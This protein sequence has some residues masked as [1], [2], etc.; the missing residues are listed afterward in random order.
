[1]RLELD[2]NGQDRGRVDTMTLRLLRV[3]GNDCISPA[4]HLLAALVKV[5]PERES[6]CSKNALAMAAALY[7]GESSAAASRTCFATFA[8][9]SYLPVPYWPFSRAASRTL[10][11][12][13]TMRIAALLPTV[14]LLCFQL[15][16]MG[17]GRATATGPPDPA[18]LERCPI[19]PHYEHIGTSNVLDMLEASPDHHVLV[20]LVQRAG[21][22]PVL[23]KLQHRGVDLT[24][25]APIDSAWPSSVQAAFSNDSIAE[26]AQIAAL[27]SLLRMPNAS[28]AQLNRELSDLLHYHIVGR[29][30][31]DYLHPPASPTRQLESTLLIPHYSRGV[32]SDKTSRSNKRLLTGHQ[33]IFAD[34]SGN[35]TF[36]WSYGQVPTE[37]SN[38]SAVTRIVSGLYGVN[39]PKALMVAVDAVLE[40]PPSLTALLQTHPQLS[41]LSSLME[42]SVGRFPFPIPLDSRDV[43]AFLPSND[44]L[45]PTSSTKLQPPLSSLQLT[46]D[47]THWL[48]DPNDALAAHDRAKLFGWHIASTENV[49]YQIPRDKKKREI[50]MTQGG[51]YTLKSPNSSNQKPMLGHAP[52]VE[53]SI[54]IENGVV[55]LLGA[56]LSPYLAPPAKSILPMNVHRLLVARGA[57]HFAFLL[58]QSGLGWAIDQPAW[59]S[60]ED[61]SHLS[62]EKTKTFDSDTVPDRLTILAL[63]DD[64]LTGLALPPGYT[65]DPD[66]MV[67]GPGQY[68]D[69]AASVAQPADETSKGILKDQLS[70]HILPDAWG[71]FNLSDPGVRTSAR[72]SLKYRYLLPTELYPSGLGG[73]RQRLD[74]RVQIPLHGDP[75]DDDDD[76]DRFDE[77]DTLSNRSIIDH[78]AKASSGSVQIT[79][80]GRAPLDLEPVTV[81]SRGDVVWFLRGALKPPQDV[82]NVLLSVGAGNVP[83]SIMS[84]GGVALF[85]SWLSATEKTRSL[86]EHGENLTGLV[87][88]DEALSANR[89]GKLL[90]NSIT[91]SSRNLAR[92]TEFAFV[93]DVVYT[94]DFPSSASESLP[95]EEQVLFTMVSAS[96]V[97]RTLE[98]GNVTLETDNSRR[99]K[100]SLTASTPVRGPGI[101]S[102][103]NGKH[104]LLT[105]TGVLHLVDSLL[106]PADMEI[107]IVRISLVSQ[108]RVL[109][110]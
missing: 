36:G 75:K 55:H 78:R 91:Q 100:E 81:G 1:M 38:K 97:Y 85:A 21:M 22:I 31:T 96:R 19:A 32:G 44:A 40:R 62:S 77:F 63:T 107:T 23:N 52:V 8:W 110:G 4:G 6:Q 106:F 16:P 41:Y 24:F 9:T 82:F 90:L 104:D 5:R 29:L 53:E 13:A 58:H 61:P 105:D 71:I 34:Y 101:T 2:T 108:N 93:H 46:S 79:F 27:G 65:V 42:L 56:A 69:L 74:V 18:K 17:A 30:L 92:L 43:V 12:G 28:S 10:E 7:W 70:Y 11:I 87:P 98:G 103:L 39:C 83:E 73:R 50:T 86:L 20:R 67:L 76:S 57:S 47:E 84:E 3:R 35:V 54:L 64:F 33:K 59:P 51:S 89:L 26:P 15:L 14:A 48:E 72:N 25:L 88:R 60:L 68:Y 94:E 95:G 80:G 99:P 102:V 66:R 109:L 45:T 37:S 49:L